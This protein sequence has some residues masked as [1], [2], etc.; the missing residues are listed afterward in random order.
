MHYLCKSSYFLVCQQE[1]QSA[2]LMEATTSCCLGR[3]KFHTSIKKFFVEFCALRALSPF[4][5]T[6]SLPSVSLLSHVSPGCG[7]RCRNHLPRQTCLA[8]RKLKCALRHRPGMSLSLQN[9]PV[10]K[11][12]LSR[13]ALECLCRRQRSLHFAFCCSWQELETTDDPLT[14]HQTRAQCCYRSLAVC[15][16]AFPAA[17]KG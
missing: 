10:V 17:L 12:I 9:T 15:A 11:V 5:S 16:K 2:F 6:A 3:L 14:S 7:L 4:S 8:L 13:A 1:S